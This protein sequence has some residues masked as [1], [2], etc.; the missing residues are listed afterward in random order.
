MPDGNMTP[1]RVRVH[2]TVR[3]WFDVDLSDPDMQKC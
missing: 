1:N 2:V 3:G